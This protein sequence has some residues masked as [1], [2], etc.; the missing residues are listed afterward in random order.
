ADTVIRQS[1]RAATGLGLSA[2]QY[3]QNANTLGALLSNQGVA[4]DELA[5]KTRGLIKTGAD[6]AATFGGDTKTAVDA[7]A[8][9]FKGEFDPLEQYGISIKQST[10]NTEAMRVA[11]VKTTAAFNDLST[12]QQAAAKQQAT[13][14]LITKQ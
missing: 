7:L 3:R 5:G 1:Q 6:L 10:V 9:A 14:N 4:A 8:S 13:A 12:A 2:D 11:N